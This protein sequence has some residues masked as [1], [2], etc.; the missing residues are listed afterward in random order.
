MKLRKGGY[1]SVDVG[2]DPVVVSFRA[3]GLVA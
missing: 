1:G 2:A 3:T